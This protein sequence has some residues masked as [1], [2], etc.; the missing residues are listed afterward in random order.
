[1]KKTIA[2][3]GLGRFGVGLVRALANKNV[4][5]IA[6]D[7]D[8]K[9]FAKVGEYIQ[10]AMI[11]D[12]TKESALRAAGI[13]EVDHAIVA[14]GQDTET[15]L[16]TTILTV[17]VLKNLGV[18]DVTC[19]IDDPYLEPLLLKIGA[20]KCISPFD[21][22]SESFALKVS[23]HSVMDYYNVTDGYNVFELEVLEGV[24]PISL[25]KL[26]SPAKFG[27]NVILVK[28]NDETF[29]PN[30]DYIIQPGDHIFVFGLEKGVFALEAFLESTIKKE[31]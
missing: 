19:R 21:I 30:K 16:A 13:D 10:N 28:R 6:I 1:M 2:I 24:E 17:I 29:Q 18:K 14:F 8:K 26:N 25:I 11:C 27:V 15:N 23:S 7:K 5:V 3:I 9:N 4:D 12:S 20:N 31:N 22:A